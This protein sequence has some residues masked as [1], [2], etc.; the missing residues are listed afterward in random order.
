VVVSGTHG[1]TTTTSLL[2]ALLHGAGRD[3][4]LLVGGYSHDFGGSFREGQ[5]EHFV[6]EG[7]E[8][9][10][11]FFDKTPKFLHYGA[12][13]LLITSVEFDHADIYRDLDHIKEAFRKLV[14]NM[15]ADG[16]IVAAVA[17][18]GVRDVVSEAPCRVLGYGVE[19]EGLDW[20]CAA[21]EAG[22]NGTHFDIV[23]GQKVVTR[24]FVP[25]FGEFN[26]ENALGAL[27]ATAVLG[28][29][30]DTAKA[31]LATFKGV[32]RRQEWRGEERGVAVIDD[33]AHH[34][35]AVRG[36]IGALRQRFADRRLIAVFEPRTNT[37]RRAIFQQDYAQSFDGA[38]RVVIRSIP[39]KPIY[40]A[41]GPIEAFFSA[42]KLVADLGERGVPATS[43]DSVEE[44]IELLTAECRSG[45][46][47]LCMSNSSFDDI[48]QRLLDALRGSA[49][50]SDR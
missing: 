3:P 46:V 12:R 15:P 30:L 1:K 25:L 41:T 18:P 6:V 37:S 27:A 9:D 40:S 32:K 14:G 38:D 13:T 48:W 17:H 5:G 23:T 31:A 43:F 11:A 47:V 21:L 42:E 45:D 50:T 36:S 39:E 8:Y 16:T 34:P 35:T 33:F 7:D 44:I 28:V 19:G 24:A 49:E 10:T 22:A 29:P 4:S 2:A 26:V 20:S